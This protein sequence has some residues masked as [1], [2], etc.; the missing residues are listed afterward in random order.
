VKVAAYIRVSTDEQAQEG[1]SIAAQKNRLEAYAVSQGWEIV[2]WYVEEGQSAKDMNRTELQRMLKGIKQNIFDVVLVYRL[3]RLTRSVLDLYELLKNFEDHGVKFKSAT[4]AYDTTTATGKLFLTLIASL[5]QWER[6]NLGERVRMGMLQ[7]AK[8][9]KWSIGLAPMGYDLNGDY[10]KVNPME[11]TIVKEIFNMY[12]SG[13]GMNKIT[14]SLNER[15]I[16]TKS[17]KVWYAG[18]VDYILK[19]PIYIGTMRYNVRVNSDQYFEMENV[20]EPIIDKATFDSVQK[21]IQEKSQIH[22]RQSGSNHIFSTILTCARCGKKLTGKTS[23]TT[24]RD[25]KYYSYNYFCPSKIRGLCDQPM[26]N[27]NHIEQKFL[28]EIK[29]WNFS[30]EIQSNLQNEEFGTVQDNQLARERLQ[31]ELDSLQEERDRWQYAW[32]KKMIKDEDLVKRLSEVEEK[33]KMILKE[34]ENLTPKESSTTNTNIAEI[35]EKIKLHWQYMTNEEKK[36][37]LLLAFDNITVDRISMTK[38]TEDYVFSDIRW[39]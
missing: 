16:R 14:K 4:E 7:K 19:N 21:L 13:M 37:F 23:F 6:E 36:Q 31:Q 15:G 32:L 34:L 24:R 20:C 35:L 38:T 9:G 22:P 1:Y 39:A 18:K 33:E 3:D 8:E 26:I 30:A 27:Q 29:E 28:N 10:L 5:A 11:A 12:L 25:K 2:Q 17:N